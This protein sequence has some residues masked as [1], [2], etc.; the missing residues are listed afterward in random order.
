MKSIRSR[1]TGILVSGLIAL[2]VVCGALLYLYVRHALLKQFDAA[3]RAR[4]DAF[5][6][7]SEQEG[8]EERSVPLNALRPEVQSAILQHAN[9]QP[10]HEIDEVTRDDAV[11]YK[12]ETVR[13]G[14]ESEFVLSANGVYVGTGADFDFA[15]SAVQSP[16]FQ[17]G[18]N[19]AFY[20]VWDE[21]G[22]LLARSRSL[23]DHDLPLPRLRGAQPSHRDVTLPDGRSGR[24]VTL[25][26]APLAEVT[27][28]DGVET[29]APGERLVL[30]IAR[31]RAELDRALGIVISGLLTTGALLAISTVLLVRSAVASGLE[32][33]REVADR[34]AAIDAE[35]LDHR[36][37]MD[38]V[39]AELRPIVCR[40]NDLLERIGAAFQRER[41]F[42]SDVAHEL[43]TPIAELRSLAEVG[44]REGN[45]DPA[46]AGHAGYLEDALAIALQMERLVHALL[47]ITR[48]QS[49]AHV[50]ERTTVDAVALVRNAWEPLERQAA[51]RELHVTM[52]C[53]DEARVESNPEL[54]SAI[55]TNVLSNAVCYCAPRGK[56]VIEM[57]EGEMCAVV[58][59][60]NP[61]T[62]LDEADLHHMFEPFWRKD[63]ARSDSNHSGVGL[64]VVAEFAKLLGVTLTVD[65]PTAGLFR[66]SL[67]LPA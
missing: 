53:P 7:M 49:G 66:V 51:A 56:I 9:G 57:S 26:F 16:E 48:S 6:A 55:L 21:D 34:A 22:E 25:A 1:L 30:A 28:P 24:V 35:S 41:R 44:L 47:A 50:V 58:R 54:L 2:L 29:L 40:L 52:E 15:F 64:A 5:I 13:N 8:G 14:A 65:M 43:R 23:E 19:A 60:S 39:P 17:P 18:P 63:K 4:A 62:E 67:Q 12:V 38:G 46:Q 59:V 45:S 36:F 32:P 27:G 42:T 3:L 10:V 31:S 20:Q 11:F 37:P 33:L 61:T